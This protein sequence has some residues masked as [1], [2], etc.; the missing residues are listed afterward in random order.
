MAAAQEEVLRRSQLPLGLLCN[1]KHGGSIVTSV[2]VVQEDHVSDHR[3]GSSRGGGG[4]GSGTVRV[5]TERCHH[6]VDVVLEFMDLGSV[7][8]LQ[9]RLGGV[10]VPPL[11]LAPIAAQMIRGLHHL[12][13]MDVVHRDVKP[14]NTLHN[15][16]GKVKIT[17]FGTV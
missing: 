5:V 2:E 11:H 7:A 15:R 16:E 6:M 3:H 12:Q 10:G 17:D 13:I 9:R 8:D 1:V 4:G 14:S